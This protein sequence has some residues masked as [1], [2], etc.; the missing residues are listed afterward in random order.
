MSPVI[1]QGLSLRGSASKVGAGRFQ[2]AAEGW[3]TFPRSQ[4]ILAASAIP[5]CAKVTGL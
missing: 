2:G 4:L 5:V 3:C 1:L